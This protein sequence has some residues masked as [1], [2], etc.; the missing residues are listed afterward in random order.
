MKT[1][2]ARRTVKGVVVYKRRKH[3]WTKKDLLRI[4]KAVTV[5]TPE[6]ELGLAV[7]ELL[8]EIIGSVVPPP[9]RYLD[10]ILRILAA[11]LALVAKNFGGAVVT[12]LAAIAGILGLEQGPAGETGPEE[13]T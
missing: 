12:L 7:A 1:S 3:R 2:K 9:L 13:E 6:E 5:H 8:W 11:L 4:A 10:N